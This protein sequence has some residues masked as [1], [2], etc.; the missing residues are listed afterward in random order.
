[1]QQPLLPC[2]WLAQLSLG[3]TPLLGGSG[4]AGSSILLRPTTRC[5]HLF[6]CD[7]QPVTLAQAVGTAVCADRGCGRGARSGSCSMLRVSL[8]LAD[9][10]VLLKGHLLLLWSRMQQW[11]CVAR[12]EAGLTGCVR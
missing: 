9:T 7:R 4:E 11:V 2:T 5:S 3:L 10:V 8:C 12:A 1:M 6:A